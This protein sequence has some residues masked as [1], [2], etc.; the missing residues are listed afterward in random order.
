MAKAQPS[1]DRIAPSVTAG[2][3]HEL[4]FGKGDYPTDVRGG[5]WAYDSVFMFD[6]LFRLKSTIDEKSPHDLEV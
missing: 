4:K 3:P 5:E 6:R 2:Q 1:P